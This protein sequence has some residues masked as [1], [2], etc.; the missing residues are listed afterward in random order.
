[1]QACADA[2]LA[3][4]DTSKLKRDHCQAIEVLF[5]LPAGYRSDAGAYFSRC[6]QWLEKALPLPILSAVIHHDEAAVHLHA[7]L[8]PVLDGRHVGSAPIARTELKRLREAF[9]SQVAG[10]AGLKR[11]GAKLRGTVKQWVVGVVLR[12]CK[13]LGMP[14]A[15]GPLWPVLVAAIERDPA[16]AMVA[17]GLDLSSVRAPAEPVANSAPA[18]PIGV[19]PN[20]I[21]LQKGGQKTQALSC[22][23]LDQHTAPKEPAK[24]VTTTADLW[25]LVGCRSMRKTPSVHRLTVARAAQRR[26]IARCSARP[27]VKPHQPARDA[28]DGLTRER[29]AYAH[30]LSAWD[31]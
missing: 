13:A 17:L 26:A 14:G 23:G 3:R 19:H 2:A 11:D 24:A 10:P 7:L 31:D 25:E 30:D 28:D 12:E 6:L 16:A 5:S 29:D 21:G 8:L 15:I 22:V 27:T 20:P 18:S 4:V 9:F 1:M